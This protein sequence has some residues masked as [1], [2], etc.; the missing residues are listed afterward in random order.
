[1]LNTIVYLVIL[2]PTFFIRQLF[3]KIGQD[4][5]IV[6]LATGFVI[7]CGIFEI[8]NFHAITNVFYAI[9]VGEYYASLVTF[10]GAFIIHLILSFILIFKFNL[11]FI[12]LI[13]ATGL[14]YLARFFLSKLY[15]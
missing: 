5:E 7:F 3:I 12:G 11:G 2:V 13:L 10:G 15:L 14:Q 9:S 4:A 8:F 6:P 1:M